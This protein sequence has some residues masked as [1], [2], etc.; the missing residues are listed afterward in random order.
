MS[1]IMLDDLVINNINYNYISYHINVSFEEY[2][3]Y[4]DYLKVII[5]GYVGDK[6]NKRFFDLYLSFVTERNI[7]FFKLYSYF[8]DLIIFLIIN[9]IQDMNDE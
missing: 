1:Y 9:L 6:E 5:R 8:L 3:L 2:E 4:F 7:A